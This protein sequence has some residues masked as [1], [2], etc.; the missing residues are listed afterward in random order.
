[1]LSLVKAAWPGASYVALD[2]SP[3]M[4]ETLR[5]LFAAQSSVTVVAHDLDEK[6]PAMG[7]FDA[8]IS[9]LRHPPSGSR[10]QAVAV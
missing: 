10:A 8:V 7:Q 1:L 9:K 2:F 4:V 5:K 3:T 6:L